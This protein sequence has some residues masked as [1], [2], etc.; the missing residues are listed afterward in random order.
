MIRGNLG[1]PFK[2]LFHTAFSDI[3]RMKLLSSIFV[4]LAT[5]DHV[6][7]PFLLQYD[8]HVSAEV[9]LHACITGV[10]GMLCVLERTV[11]IVIK[12]SNIFFFFNRIIISFLLRTKQYVKNV[13]KLGH[14]SRF[15][16][17]V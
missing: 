7:F 5:F 10:C 1:K 8:Y 15:Q 11:N 16:L 12:L 13:S 6:M 14:Y 9:V 2:L 4:L 17:P 3:E